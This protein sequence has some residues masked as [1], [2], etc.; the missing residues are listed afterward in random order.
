[1]MSKLKITIFFVAFLSLVIA[2]HATYP[3]WSPT[4]TDNVTG[5]GSVY[6]L[7][8]LG[9][10]STSGPVGSAVT[11]SGRLTVNGT[12]I[13]VI[14]ATVRLFGGAGND[15]STWTQLMTQSTDSS[16]NFLFT[17]IRVAPVG[18]WTYA[19]RYDAP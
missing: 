7:S 16:G 3:I 14:G 11:Y 5:Q 18:N 2:V 6:T 19:V 17:V 9:T 15:N 10:N 13:P 12:I 1:M 4:I 8:P